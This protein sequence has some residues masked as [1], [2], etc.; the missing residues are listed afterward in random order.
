MNDNQKNIEEWEKE[1]KEA[2]NNGEIWRATFCQIL[3]NKLKEKDD[4]IN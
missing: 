4:E 1:A 2:L 3:A